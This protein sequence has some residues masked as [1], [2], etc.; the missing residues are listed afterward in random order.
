MLVPRAHFKL[1][2]L[3]RALHISRF[4]AP[5]LKNDLKEPLTTAPGARQ[6]CFRFGLG[7][8]LGQLSRLKASASQLSQAPSLALRVSVLPLPLPSPSSSFPPFELS[9]STQLHG[10]PQP[11]SPVAFAPTGT[12][13]LQKTLQPKSMTLLLSLHLSLL[14]AK[15]ANK[16]PLRHRLAQPVLLPRTFLQSLSCLSFSLSFKSVLSFTYKHSALTLKSKPLSP[17]L[18]ILHHIHLS[19]E[20][21]ETNI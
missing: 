16:S 12:E 14:P 19:V 8:P 11:L 20:I 3:L 6:A 17:L 18:Q 13:S 1:G 2:T 10:A 15:V 9:L 21:V 5:E 7:L 4:Q